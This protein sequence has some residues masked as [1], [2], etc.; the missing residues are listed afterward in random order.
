MIT[1]CHNEPTIKSKRKCS[2]HSTLEIRR[3]LNHLHD[4][5]S[6]I[7]HGTVF[8]RGSQIEEVNADSVDGMFVGTGVHGQILEKG[9]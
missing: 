6:E 2:L 1:D 9:R 5:S 4:G 7:R 3:K 8:A